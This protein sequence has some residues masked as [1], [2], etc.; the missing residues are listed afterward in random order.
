MREYKSMEEFKKA[1]LPK[2]YREELMKSMSSEELAI[3]MADESL[4]KIKKKLKE[5]K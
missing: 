4:E 3:F 1:F 2:S 5:G